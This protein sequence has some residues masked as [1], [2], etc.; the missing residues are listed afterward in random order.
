M[1][2]KFK[3]FT[4]KLGVKSKKIEKNIAL[5]MVVARELFTPN[6]SVAYE[7]STPTPFGCDCEHPI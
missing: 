3:S 4:P 7:P 1:G 6:L 2:V 5:V